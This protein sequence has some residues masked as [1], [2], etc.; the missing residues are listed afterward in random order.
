MVEWQKTSVFLSLKSFLYI[1]NLCCVYIILRL[2]NIFGQWSFL[3][4]PKRLIF[5]PFKN[6]IV[7]AI[8]IPYVFQLKEVFKIPKKIPTSSVPAETDSPL[9]CAPPPPITRTQ[10]SAPQETPSSMPTSVSS[11]GPSKSIVQSPANQAKK[12]GR[13]PKKSL[14]AM[15]IK[16]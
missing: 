10:T 5:F 14:D 2:A 7:A 15:I 6:N 12:R 3:E 9:P 13:P 1:K 4:L 11:P 16:T 8:C